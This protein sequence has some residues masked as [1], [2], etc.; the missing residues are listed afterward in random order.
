MLSVLP[1]TM[2]GALPEDIRGATKPR[3][4]DPFTPELKIMRRDL[5]TLAFACADAVGKTALHYG[6]EDLWAIGTMP[7]YEPL[8]DSLEGMARGFLSDSHLSAAHTDVVT[9]TIKMSGDLRTAARGARQAVQ[10]A[11][12]FRADRGYGAQ[13]LELLSPMAEAVSA[14]A[15]RAAFAAQTG[16]QSAATQAVQAFRNVDTLRVQ[17]ETGICSHSWDEH[18]PPTVQRL[19]RAATWN[20]AVSGESMARVAA[21][22]IA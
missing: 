16:D 6:G 21:R 5:A 12:L 9:G 8:A 4:D 10:I 14:V 7:G 18:F 13:A 11:F 2:L 15:E 3:K 1:D 22:L 17:V 19:I 20:F